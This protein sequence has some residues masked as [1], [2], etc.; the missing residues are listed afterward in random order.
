MGETKVTEGHTILCFLARYPDEPFTADD[1]ACE[2]GSDY[3]TVFNVLDAMATGER[4]DPVERS[5][6]RTGKAYF[7]LSDRGEIMM[8]EQS[9]QAKVSPKVQALIYALE[10]FARLA[11]EIE[12][13][14]R[15]HADDPQMND[16]TCW[17]KSCTWD[18]LRRARS[19]LQSTDTAV[20]EV[21]RLI[22]RLRAPLYWWCGSSPDDERVDTAPIDA[23][24]LLE[25]HFGIPH[26]RGALD[27]AADALGAHL[28]KQQESG[29]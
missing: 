2:I 28:P 3:E 19:A 4:G 13:M 10:P 7:K 26:I 15:Q 6:D 29:Q 21:A 20:G 16:P 8:R 23:A 27:D 25:A 17:S 5:H 9:A 12:E 1:I 14:C 24:D 22:Q 18:D 11:D